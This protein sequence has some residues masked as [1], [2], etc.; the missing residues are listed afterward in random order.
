M[1]GSPLEPGSLEDLRKNIPELEQ[2]PYSIDYRECFLDGKPIDSADANQELFNFLAEQVKTYHDHYDGIVVVYGTD[3]MAPSAASVAY[4]LEGLKKPVVFTGSMHDRETKPY[5]G[6]RNLTDAIH[7]AARSGYDVPLVPEV[8][9]SFYGKVLRGTRSRKFNAGNLHNLELDPSEGLDAFD[10]PGME[11]L[12]YI[13][14]DGTIN[15]NKSLLLEIDE[16]PLEAHPMRTDLKVGEINMIEGL[17]SEHILESRCAGFHE[18]GVEVIL[19]YETGAKLNP[20][21]SAIIKKYFPDTPIF[22]LG[23]PPPEPSWIGSDGLR[24]FQLAMAKIQYVLSR[25]S[26]PQATREL[27]QS[28][29]RGEAK[30]PLVW[31]SDILERFRENREINLNPESRL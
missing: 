27:Y 2:L 19:I 9:I 31:E 18:G 20:K 26:E 28:N 23:D 17:I 16:R 4:E 22:Y 12:A 30:G 21:N 25:T 8:V 29:L 11:P 14:E 6:P 1:S 24:D 10:S 13:R 7:F 15:V 3:T 5:D